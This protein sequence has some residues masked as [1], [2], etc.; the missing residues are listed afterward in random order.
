MQLKYIWFSSSDHLKK[1]GHELDALPV[2]TKLVTREL[3]DH[4]F[5]FEG[6]CEITGIAFTPIFVLTK[7]LVIDMDSS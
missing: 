3:S 4:A 1:L 5:R 2:T 7:V 6:E